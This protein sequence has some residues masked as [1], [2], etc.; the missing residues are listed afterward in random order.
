MAATVT[1]DK[2]LQ[3][4]AKLSDDGQGKLV[5]EMKRR[6]RKHAAWLRQLDKDAKQAV[7]DAKAGKHKSFNSTRELTAY[8]NK[9]C[10]ASS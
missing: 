1:L 4:A 7:E 9:V 3:L 10:G 2:V 5:E 6:Q 8:T